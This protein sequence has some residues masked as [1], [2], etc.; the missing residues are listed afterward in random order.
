MSFYKDIQEDLIKK[1][2]QG[3]IKETFYESFSI[4]DEFL[5]P[6]NPWVDVLSGFYRSKQIWKKKFAKKLINTSLARED[7]KINYIT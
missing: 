1:L 5:F 4:F 3:C 7:S 2:W 6:R